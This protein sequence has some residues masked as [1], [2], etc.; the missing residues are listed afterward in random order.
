MLAGILVEAERTAKAKSAPRGV[1][2]PSMARQI[3]GCDVAGQQR[4]WSEPLA[5]EPVAAL[6]LLSRE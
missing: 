1:D 3:F 6:S 4:V 2:A 5:R